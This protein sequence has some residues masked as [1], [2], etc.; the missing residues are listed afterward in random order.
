[1]SPA[2]PAR[3]RWLVLAV[4]VLSSSINYLDRMALATLAPVVRGEFHLSNQQYGWIVA[5]F[6]IAYAA[7][8]PVAGMWIDHPR[9]PL[10][11][12][13]RKTNWIRLRPSS[14]RVL[15]GCCRSINKASCSIY[16]KG[17]SKTGVTLRAK[18]TAIKCEAF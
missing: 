18:N 14:S 17:N 10:P 1:M 6:S 13:N 4:F 16:I 11:S 12:G 8:A 15:P 5:A 9:I 3:F 2:D 7:S